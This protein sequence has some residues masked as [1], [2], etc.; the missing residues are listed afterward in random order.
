MDRAGLRRAVRAVAG[1]ALPAAGPV[2]AAGSPP[3]MYPVLAS[4]DGA[5]FSPE[6]GHGAVEWGWVAAGAMISAAVVVLLWKVRRDALQQRERE[7]QQQ[8]R[9]LETGRA[10]VSA[11]CRAREEADAASRAKTEFLATMSHEI[12][13]PLNGVIGSAELMLGTALDPQQREYMTTLRASAE[14]LLAVVNDILDFSRIE[15]GCMPIERTLFNLRKPLAD[16]VKI[17]AARIGDAAVELVLDVDP[18]VPTSLYGDAA[19]IRQVLLKLVANAVKFTKQGHVVVRVTRLD[20]PAD[21]AGVWLE[22]AVSD[23][24]IGIAEEDQNRLFEKFTQADSS[25]TRRHGGTGLGL[26]IAKG[27]VALMQGEIGVES[28]PGRGSRFCF[29]LP[30]KADEFPPPPETAVAARV[31][32]IDDL[33]P[34]AQALGTL[35]RSMQLAGE[36]A[37]A[38]EALPML[39]RAAEEKQPFDAVMIDQ[40]VTEGGDGEAVRAILAAP[41]CAGIR[42]ILLAQPKSSSTA[43]P[44]PAGFAAVV[45]KPVLD[46][47]QIVHAIQ[48][49]RDAAATT[50]EPDASNSPAKKRLKLLVAEDNGVNRVV[51]GGMLKKLGCQVDFA[52]NGAE[53]V[54]KSRQ[55]GYDMILMDCL[56]PEMDGWTA[57]R[58]IRRRDFRIPIIAVTANATN[59]DRTRC[60]KAGMNDYLSKPLRIAELSRVMERWTG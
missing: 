56:M 39:R 9:E 25:S 33:P 36:V 30:L 21:P 59:D 50:D 34:A 29:S 58:E 15:E 49:S 11:A 8:E 14:S 16:V 43:Q 41:E 19:R 44:L 35:L 1:I 54:A 6:L 13:T 47:D 26:A 2:L 28:T 7:K 60:M 22:F 42:F 12:R 51:A 20:R 40:S 53:A 52:E 24:G 18:E 48:E 32:V 17:A 46:V 55:K 57:T 23:T 27:L 4:F 3:P 31:L 37:S 45:T 10:Q 38:G 5:G